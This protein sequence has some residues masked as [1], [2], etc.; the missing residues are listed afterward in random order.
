MQLTRYH[1]VF[2]PHSQ[3]RAA[4]TPAHRGMGSTGQGADAAGE[5][6]QRITPHHVA[7]SWAQRLKRV[8]GVEIST[9]AR[10]SNDATEKGLLPAGHCGPG[11]VCARRQGVSGERECAV[12]IRGWER[13]AGRCGGDSQPLGLSG[14]GNRWAVRAHDKARIANW[15]AAEGRLK[16][17]SAQVVLRFT[18]LGENDRLLSRTEFRSF[19]KCGPCS[20]RIGAARRPSIV[21]LRGRS[22][23]PRTG[24]VARPL[25]LHRKVPLGACGTACVDSRGTASA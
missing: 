8:F 17:L 20:A 15:T 19:G 2:A 24:L 1:G 7:M 25:L 9:C 16:V 4:V 5:P 22:R 21:R 3:L 11:S 13:P 23:A 10:C 14:G 12:Q 18:R 6:D